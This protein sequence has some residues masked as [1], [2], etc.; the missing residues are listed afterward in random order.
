MIRYPPVSFH[1]QVS[2][3]GI[4]D[5]TIDSGFQSVSGLDVTMQTEEI[6][7]GGEN[8]YT[9]HLP[10]RASYPNLILE[11]GLIVESKLIDWCQ[12]T[13][14]NMEIKP[15]SLDIILLNEE[16]EPLMTWNIVHAWPVKWSVSDLN[17]QNNEIA[18]EKLE[19]KYR[20]FSIIK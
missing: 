17:A 15:V 13:F 18:I 6:K 12:N 16:H 20:S 2:F 7:E 5:R 4:G 14:L 1:Y 11:R 10:L 3:N 19:L 8:G 9:H